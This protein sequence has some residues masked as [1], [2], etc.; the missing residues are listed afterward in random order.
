MTMGK[1]TYSILFSEL[2]LDRCRFDNYD[3]KWDVSSRPHHFHLSQIKG[4][5]N[6]PM[7]G[8]PEFDLL[9]LINLLKSKRLT[10]PALRF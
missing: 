4:G 7:S 8:E 5:F 1:Y 6:S 10:D 9:L 2:E 3:D